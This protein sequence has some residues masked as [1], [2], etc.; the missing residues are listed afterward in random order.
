MQAPPVTG[1]PVPSRVLLVGQAPGRRE[2]EAGRPFTWTAGRTLFG[3]LAGIGLEE[4]RVR[5]RVYLAAVCRCFPGRTAS[6]G[7]RA[8]DRG[9]IRRCAHWL[10]AELDLLRPRLVLP[11]GRLAIAWFLQVDRLTEVVG[12]RHRVEAHGHRVDVIPLP[13]PSGA[14]P[15]HKTSPGRELLADALEQI[16]A[17]PAWRALQG[18]GSG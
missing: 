17:H 18:E 12:R 4:A 14:S 5:E 3:W 10:E 13:H 15:W 8:P 6:G 1:A 9:E 11:V 7:D 2:R 16:A